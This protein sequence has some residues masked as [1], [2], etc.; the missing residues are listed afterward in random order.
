MKKDVISLD[1]ILKIIIISTK[2]Y[3]FLPFEQWRYKFIQELAADHK[4]GPRGRE[5]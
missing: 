2:E 1:G 5:I 3:V 4:K